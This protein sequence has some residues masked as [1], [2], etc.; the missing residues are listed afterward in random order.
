MTGPLF[1]C[2]VHMDSRNASDYES[3][4]L[5]GVASVLV[6][7]SFTGE[8]KHC[9]AAYGERFDRLLGL[10]RNRASHFG[11]DLRVALAVNANDA[12][13]PELAIDAIGE[14]QA[15]LSDPAVRAIGELSFRDFSRHERRLFDAQLEL[16]RER[17]L[18]VIVEAPPGVHALNNLLEILDVA[19]NTDKIDR[20]RVCLVDL[21]EEKLELASRLDLGGYGIPVSPRI[22]GLFCLHPKLDHREVMRLVER[23]GSERLMLNSALHFGFADSLCF[24]KTVLRL[25]L[26]GVDQ[27]VLAKIAHDNAEKFFSGPAN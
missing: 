10:E 5:A 1:D 3:M 7:C 2:H 6:P 25:R 24:P 19:V 18:P 16:A 13:D 9:T 26:A 21:N 22:D 15:R 4:A 17:G 12:G 23:Y 20:R 11:V 14:L 8:R 27:A